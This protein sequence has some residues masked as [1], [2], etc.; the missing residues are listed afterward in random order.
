MRYLDWQDMYV[1]ADEYF[2]ILREAWEKSEFFDG[3]DT[4]WHP[5]D[6]SAN[7]EAVLDGVGQ[8]ITAYTHLVGKKYRAKPEYDSNKK[9][10]D[11]MVKQAANSEPE[12]GTP[13]TPSVSF[14]GN[15]P[16]Q[17]FGGTL[18]RGEWDNY[19]PSPVPPRGSRRDVFGDNA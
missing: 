18:P 16:T 7:L 15:Y 1:T 6:L 12:T 17:V 9:T 4:K 2:A 5:E 11:D 13:N 10:V 14:A 19:E 8:G 3:W